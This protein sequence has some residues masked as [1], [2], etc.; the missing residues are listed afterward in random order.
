MLKNRLVEAE[1]FPHQFNLLCSGAVVAAYRQCL[2][3]VYRGQIG[4]KESQDSNT[5]QDNNEQ[6]EPSQ[7]SLTHISALT[8]L[9]FRPAMRHDSAELLEQTKSA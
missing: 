7:Y 8:S 2:S 1:F 5:K 9:L 4:V 3:R 6:A